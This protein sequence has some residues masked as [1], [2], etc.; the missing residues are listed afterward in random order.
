MRLSQEAKKLLFAAQNQA[1][2]IVELLCDA[3]RIRPRVRAGI[4]R[5]RGASQSGKV[6]IAAIHRASV[7]SWPWSLNASTTPSVN[8]INAS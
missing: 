2:N 7:N 6:W 3:R 5:E 1:G 8:R 4:A